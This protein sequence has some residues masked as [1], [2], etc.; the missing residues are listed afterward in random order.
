MTLHR[1][2]SPTMDSAFFMILIASI[3]LTATSVE[4]LV[5]PSPNA[6][7]AASCSSQAYYY[8][9]R[10]SHF[11][12]QNSLHYRPAGSLYAERNQFENYGYQQHQGP[13][14]NGNWSG[15][16]AANQWNENSQ[17]EGERQQQQQQEYFNGDVGY[18]NVN[19]NSFADQSNNQYYYEQQP[20]QEGN[21]R[22]GSYD[23]NEQFDVQY[24]QANGVYDGQHYQ[25]EQNQ[26]YGQQQYYPNPNQDYRGEPN[27][28]YDGQQQLYESNQDYNRQPPNGS[29]QDY[30]YQEPPRNRQE[31]EEDIY[32]TRRMDE[33][34]LS[35]GG[36]ASSLLDE[37]FD[38]PF[39]DDPFFDNFFS[40]PTPFNML[41]PFYHRNRRR[42]GGPFSSMVN[43]NFMS[44][45]SMLDRMQEKMQDFSSS[46]RDGGFL[47]RAEGSSGILLD[48][49]ERYLNE[50]VACRMALGVGNE[51]R[52]RLGRILGS[53]SSTAYASVWDRG[54][55]RQE[56]RD[57]RNLQVAVVD[58]NGRQDDPASKIE[59]MV[60][61]TAFGDEAEIQSLTLQTRDGQEISVPVIGRNNND[62]NNGNNN[63]NFEDGRL[64]NE[65][66]SREAPP[67]PGVIDAEVVEGR[68]L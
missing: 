42:R 9:S 45:F 51:A 66:P 44:A 26:G 40:M 8:C 21:D 30:A 2:T 57:Q 25:E 61:I 38:D 59:A 56:R 7:A 22:Q 6:P 65:D 17:F 63:N 55:Q 12:L 13:N 29:N 31:E 68:R 47:E 27:G 34:G 54:E 36:S 50:D 5:P 28:V 33:R 15:G 67:P 58:D 4:A 1:T 41:S 37:M 46:S 52:I 35:R 24:K 3:A 19:Y 62:S 60:R 39:F 49:A 18:N 11:S 20:T 23:F 16:A 43:P 32:P 64:L 14:E 10:K 48:K 53:S